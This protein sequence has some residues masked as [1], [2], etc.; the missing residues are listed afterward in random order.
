MK[1]YFSLTS[2]PSR[3]DKL[4]YVIQSLI[5]QEIEPEKIFLHIPLY[6][7]RF[8]EFICKD[9]LIKLQKKFEDKLFINFISNDYG[10]NTKFLPMLQM[11]NLLYNDYI[12]EIVEFDKNLPI[13]ILD[14]DFAY[15]KKLSLTLLNLSTSYP[16]SACCMF[17]ITNCN[18][19]KS[20][21]WIC[22]NNTQ[23]KF[24]AGFRGEIEGYIDIFEGFCG[25]L[26]K[27]KFFQNDVFDIPDDEIYFCDDVWLSG[28]VIKN[29]FTI[30]T[31]S[32]LLKNSEG[33]QDET[34]A[35]KND[36]KKLH[37]DQLTLNKLQE[38]YKIFL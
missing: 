9:N 5:E 16:N 3:F 29:G 14:D 17:G 28:H 27:T 36:K 7:K 23:N 21:Q 33:V 37:R 31:S 32:I 13:I 19:I 30:V 22:D 11:K 6:Y 12:D 1:Y 2:I 4:D 34:D 18:W 8:N 35:L 24:P 25:V 38:L 20:K 15:D 26:L 10:S